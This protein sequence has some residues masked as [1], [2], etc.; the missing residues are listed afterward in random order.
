MK[1]VLF[2]AALLLTVAVAAQTKSYKGAWFEVK[3][4][5]NFSV[6][7]S[8][9]SKMGEANTYDAA[10][11]TSPDKKVSFYI[12]AP[13]VPVEKDPESVPLGN[14]SQSLDPDKLGFVVTYYSNFN[15]KDKR[16]HSYQVTRTSEGYTDLIIGIAYT[17]MKDY[18]KYKKQ[19]LAFKKS[20]ERYYFD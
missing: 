16:T 9:P 6:K 4:P 5:S 3:Y 2:F 15:N 13:V 20:L 17:T 11:F 12:Y 14:A 19:Y 7:A 8:E 10:T 18:E 1:K